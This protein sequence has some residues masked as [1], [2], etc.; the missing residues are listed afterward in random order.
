MDAQLARYCISL[1][2]ACF[3]AYFDSN[4]KRRKAWELRLKGMPGALKE[5]VDLA[6]AARPAFKRGPD[7]EVVCQ[8]I[9]DAVT[10]RL[11]MDKADAA[12]GRRLPLHEGQQKRWDLAELIL[13]YGPELNERDRQHRWDPLALRDLKVIQDPPDLR[14]LKDRKD[15]R[16]NRDP[17]DLQGLIPIGYW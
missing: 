17:P 12:E 7:L 1:V 6:W 5:D 13:R 3:P 2:E 11:E 10:E 16:A 15:L 9:R 14:D 8:S 4:T